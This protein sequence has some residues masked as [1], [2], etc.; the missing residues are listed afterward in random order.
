AVDLDPL[1]TRAWNNAGVIANRIGENRDAIDFYTNAIECDP[2]NAVAYRN[3]GKTWL[4]LGKKANAQ[5]D[6]HKA[7]KLEGKPAEP[8][9]AD[10]T[11][12]PDHFDQLDLTSEQKEQVVKI[13]NSYEAKTAELKHKLSD[14]SKVPGGTSIVIAAAN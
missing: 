3:R 14:A 8:A 12:L 9:K 10:S 4:T 5:A 2:D 1:F 6:I 13:M 7:D 11:S